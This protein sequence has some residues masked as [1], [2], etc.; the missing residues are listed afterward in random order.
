M[1]V[2]PYILIHAWTS[3]RMP[4]RLQRQCPRTPAPKGR[5]PRQ[6]RLRSPES[7]NLKGSRPEVPPAEAKPPKVNF[8]PKPR[9][10]HPR[11]KSD[12]LITHSTTTLPAERTPAKA[13]PECLRNRPTQPLTG[14]PLSRKATR[15]GPPSGP[16]VEETPRND[17]TFR[18]VKESDC[19]FDANHTW[20]R[21]D[22]ILIREMED[23]L[24]LSQ[25]ILVDVESWRLICSVRIM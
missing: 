16:E 19:E 20:N 7:V 18:S 11:A 9:N 12:T 6:A 24:G 25:E 4:R 14:T 2:L 23:Y 21:K 17:H 22:R 1:I 3:Q 8:S 5:V 10:W 13:V 15:L